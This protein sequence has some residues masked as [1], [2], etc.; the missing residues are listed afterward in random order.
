M[1]TITP[2]AVSEPNGSIVGAAVCTNANVQMRGP[3]AC[4]TFVRIGKTVRRNV[5]GLGS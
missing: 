4:R 3:V 2:E 1:R 5:L